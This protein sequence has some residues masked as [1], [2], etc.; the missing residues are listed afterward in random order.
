MIAHAH[1]ADRRQSNCDQQHHI[2]CRRHHPVRVVSSFEKTDIPPAVQDVVN[3]QEDGHGNAKPFVQ[4]FAA[5][6][7]G[8]QTKQGHRHGDVHRH[9]DA[10]FL[11]VRHL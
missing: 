8:H 2:D 4:G 3:D 9:P 5:D 1:A 11:L 7:I 10:V 6:L